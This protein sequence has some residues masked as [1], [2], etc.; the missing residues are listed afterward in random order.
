MK[1]N[2]LLFLLLLFIGGVLQ[3]CTSDDNKDLELGI[4]ELPAIGG[5]SATYDL[6]RAVSA[7][8]VG[9]SYTVESDGE[10]VVNCSENLLKLLDWRTASSNNAITALVDLASKNKNIIILDEEISQQDLDNNYVGKY[11]DVPLSKKVIG[12]TSNG[13]EVYVMI[14]TN[15]SEGTEARKIYDFL[16][17][18]AGQAAITKCGYTAL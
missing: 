1:K 17:T 3:S 15:D 8:W 9:W 14:R 5:T 12:H 10:V 7:T 11:D 16:T 2:S 4:R 6:R 13:E 18:P